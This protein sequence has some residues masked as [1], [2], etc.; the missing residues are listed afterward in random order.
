LPQM[1]NT[2]LPF[3]STLALLYFAFTSAQLFQLAALVSRYQVKSACSAALASFRLLAAAK[4]R[5]RFRDMTCMRHRI[6]CSQV[7]SK[8]ISRRFGTYPQQSIADLEPGP[9]PSLTLRGQRL[10]LVGFVL[11]GLR[12]RVERIEDRIDPVKA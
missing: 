11:R 8:S 6:I 12:G 7:G 2:I 1:L 9:A 5:I 4:S 3:F 10:L